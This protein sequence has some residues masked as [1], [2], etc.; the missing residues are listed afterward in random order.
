MHLFIPAFVCF[1]V[2]IYLFLDLF[3]YLFF[4]TYVIFCPSY[5]C[6]I[7]DAGVLFLYE[8]DCQSKGQTN[9][10]FFICKTTS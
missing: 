9:L 10:F 1:C 8:T 5:G 4:Y 6:G 3:I 7:P 2:I